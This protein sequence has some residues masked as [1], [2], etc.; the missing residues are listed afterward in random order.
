MFNDGRDSD[1]NRNALNDYWNAKTVVREIPR[2]FSWLALFQMNPKSRVTN[3]KT[4]ARTRAERIIAVYRAGT[5][6]IVS[7]YLF[8]SNVTVKDKI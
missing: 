2:V 4:G 7:Y 3:R 1:R 6:F 5:L 8:L